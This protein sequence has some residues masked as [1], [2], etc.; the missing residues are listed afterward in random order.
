MQKIAINKNLV[1]R[2]AKLVVFG[3]TIMAGNLWAATSAIEGI[4]KDPNGRPLSGVDIRIEAKNQSFSTV[5]KSDAKGHY[6]CSALTAGVTYRVNLMVNGVVKASINNV[7]TK[8]GDPTQLNF[9]LR[10]NKGSQASAAAKKGKHFVWMPSQ[11]GSH[12]GGRWVEVDDSGQ[13]DTAGANNLQTVDGAA[14]KKMQNY[15]GSV[16]GASPH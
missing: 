11:T 6:L 1:P 9:D 8:V 15:G 12:T 13:A 16:P 3:F 5:V 14:L 2:L 10:T 7:K 4:V